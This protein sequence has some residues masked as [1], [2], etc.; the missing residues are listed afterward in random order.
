MGF[1]GVEHVRMH[2]SRSSRKGVPVSIGQR[3]HSIFVNPALA[4]EGREG[5]LIQVLPIDTMVL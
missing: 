5:H 2:L 4:I 3:V 1:S